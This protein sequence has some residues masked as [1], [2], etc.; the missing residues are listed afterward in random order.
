MRAVLWDMDGTLVD[1]EK[2]WGV[3]LNALY[4]RLGGRLTVRVREATVGSSAGEAMRIVHTDLGLSLDAAAMA[5]STEYLH[6]HVGAL[7]AAGLPWCA[8]AR[9]LL[10][11]L[12]AAA[13]PMALVTNT[14]RSLT[15][16]ALDSIGRDHFSASVCGDEVRHGK[17]APDSY[18]AAA[19]ALGV[20]PAQCLA[21]EDSPTGVTAARAAGCPVLVVPNAVAVPAGPGRKRA[22]SLADF[23][24]AG[25][26]A[27]HRELLAAETGVTSRNSP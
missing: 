23:D 20:T 9:E 21:V 25:L 24:V 6:G 12:A 19:A 4:A 10:A 15:E 13:I 5:A 18:R 26:R 16:R 14:C 22:A 17:P 1:S 2:L 8:G 3:A 11:E 7:F 27:V